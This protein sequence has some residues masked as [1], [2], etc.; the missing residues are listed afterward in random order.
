MPLET[1]SAACRKPP[2]STLRGLRPFVTSSGRLVHRTVE[3]H[4]PRRRDPVAARRDHAAV[5]EARGTRCFSEW[6]VPPVAADDHPDV[7]LVARGPG[8]SWPC[9][10]RVAH[11][12]PARRPLAEGFPLCVRR[13]RP[14]GL[15]PE[16]GHGRERSPPGRRRVLLA[17]RGMPSTARTVLSP[18]PQRT[19]SSDSPGLPRGNSPTSAAELFGRSRLPVKKRKVGS[20]T[21]S[22]DSTCAG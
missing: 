19:Y 7:P 2:E 13:S 12:K 9:T 15:H 22:L 17:R 3:H 5:D 18:G 16:H 21:R 1:G 10:E 6:T 14:P 20:V 8:C 11:R 4:V